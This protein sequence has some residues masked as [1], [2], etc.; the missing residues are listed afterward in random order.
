M[1]FRDLVLFAAIP[2]SVAGITTK[3]CAQAE[4]ARRTKVPNANKQYLPAKLE[5]KKFYIVPGNEIPGIPFT[6][7]VTVKNNQKID[8]GPDVWVGV[9]VVFL[10]E[11][12]NMIKILEQKNSPW[13]GAWG[14]DVKQYWL[15]P[16]E[17][18]FKIAFPAPHRKL[19]PSDEAALKNTNWK[20]G[21]VV[22]VNA[23]PNNKDDKASYIDFLPE[24]YTQP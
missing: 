3:V 16:G 8:A 24:Q 22:S 17:T 14:R 6:A 10:D 1:S 2:L 20:F 11:K 18:V 23:Y 13:G 12:K 15:K 21:I 7:M 5:I 19:S 4:G 9:H